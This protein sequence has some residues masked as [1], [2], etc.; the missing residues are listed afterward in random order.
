M[1][2]PKTEEF[3]WEPKPYGIIPLFIDVGSMFDWLSNIL[4][5]ALLA[6]SISLIC[7]TS[8]YLIFLSTSSNDLYG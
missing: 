5:V 4:E 7:T 8:L 3:T 6:I 2:A 1:E